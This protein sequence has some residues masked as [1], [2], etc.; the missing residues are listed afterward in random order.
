GRSYRDSTRITA[1]VRDAIA[2]QAELAPSHN[3]LELEA[4]QAVDRVFGEATPQIAVFD[5]AFHAT[6][7]PAAYVYPGPHE[8]L[9]QGIRRFGFHGI[10]HQYASPRAAQLMG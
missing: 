8:W 7:P 5:T 2:Q 6:L 9:D 10:S 4:I 1:E 3:R